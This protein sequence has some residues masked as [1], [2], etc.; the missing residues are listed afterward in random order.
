MKKNILIVS[1]EF[2]PQPG[3]IGNH[4]FN[5]ASTLS[6]KGFSVTLIAD[7]RSEDGKP[8][9][10]FD[11]GLPFSVQR[12]KKRTFRVLMY[13]ERLYWLIKN[14]KKADY[15]F[16][17]GKFSLWSVAFCTQ[18]MR[19]FTLAIV[20]GS[21]VNLSLKPSRML[22]DWSLKQCNKVVA[23]SQYTKGFMNHLNLPVMVIP[24]GIKVKNW[25]A[26]NI[27]TKVKE[28]VGSPKLITVGRVSER[29]GQ[30]DV[31]A[32]L[33][34]LIKVFPNLHY[35]CI[36]IHAEGQFVTEMTKVLEVEN[37]VS[38]HGVI[39]NDILKG[40]LAQSD[41]FAMLSKPGIKGDVEGFGIAIL[42]ANTMG[43]PAIGA[44]GSGVEEAIEVG[45]SG[46]I[47]PLG[48][49]KAFVAAVREI[50]NNKAHYKEGAENWA[51][52]HDWDII[53]KKYMQ[54]LP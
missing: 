42:E 3:G 12:I 32:M 9:A 38:F 48:D 19:R 4:A 28:L 5:L 26:E 27:K 18:F 14:L 7:Q 43:I 36:G 1:S 24:N 46:A 15:V 52:A 47:V 50:L 41:V 20:H 51:K 23:V 8:E 35:H 17:S 33:P 25:Q 34:E 44:F 29:K 31:V 39:E 30:G 53:I 49:S 6:E 16:A 40:Y 2:P 11:G 21:E 54:L 45:Q 10:L 13:F 37:H 22:V